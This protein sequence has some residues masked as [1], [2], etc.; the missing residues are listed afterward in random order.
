M[1]CDRIVFSG[2]ALQRMFER[3]ID[4]IDVETVLRTGEAI[5]EYP[6]ELPYPSCLMLGFV[7]GRAIHVVVSF[8][9]HTGTCY[10]ITVYPPDPELWDAEFKRRRF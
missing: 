4:S 3:Q 5:A 6:D 2:H 7:E 10:V 1:D 8:D 9:Q